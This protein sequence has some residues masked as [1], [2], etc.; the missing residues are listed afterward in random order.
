MCGKCGELLFQ[1]RALAGRTLRLFGTVYD[2]FELLA[3]TLADIFKNWHDASG[4][5]PTI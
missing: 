1:L 2:C 4:G 3:A 5:T